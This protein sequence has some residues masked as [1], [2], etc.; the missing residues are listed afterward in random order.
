MLHLPM[1]SKYL[2]IPLII[3][4]LVF[5]IGPLP[6]AQAQPL[7]GLPEPGAMVSSG[8]S[9]KRGGIDLNQKDMGW[10]VRKKGKGVEMTI[11]PV[12]IERIKRDGIESSTPVIFRIT[13]LTNIWPLLG[14]SPPEIAAT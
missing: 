12:M 8:S 3:A 2:N 13:P 7:L 11:D 10:T 5:S 1:P 6:Q 14:L 4:L 9:P